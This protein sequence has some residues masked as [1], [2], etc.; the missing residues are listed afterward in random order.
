MNH[1]GWI[2]Y[3]P[4]AVD[5]LLV[6]DDTLC[7]WRHAFWSRKSGTYEKVNVNDL[8]RQ[9]ITALVWEHGGNSVTPWKCDINE[10]L[11]QLRDR[12][13]L[14]YDVD[15]DEKTAERMEP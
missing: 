15:L 1:W 10:V 8:R 13:C 7:F 12:V 6:W 5:R 3:T 4:A 9:C 2:K 11:D 14:F